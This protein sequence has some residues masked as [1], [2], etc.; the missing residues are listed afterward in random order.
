[1]GKSKRNR[2]KQ[3][4]ATSQQP[5]AAKQQSSTAKQRSTSSGR[6]LPIVPITFGVVAIVIAIVVIAGSGAQDVT[7]V[8]G[9]ASRTIATVDECQFTTLAIAIPAEVTSEQAA[10]DIFDA[11]SDITG[12]GL[13]SVYEDDPRVEIDYCQSYTS[14]PELRSVLAEAGYLAQ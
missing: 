5:A 14:E 6:K 9:K 10:E 4:A 3:P 8:D 1:M 13:V 7:F 12:V 11:L 2:N